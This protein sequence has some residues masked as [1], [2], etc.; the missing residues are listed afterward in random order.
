MCEMEF[1]AQ[2]AAAAAR[3][4]RSVSPECRANALKLMGDKLLSCKSEL[5]AANAADIAGLS[6]RASVE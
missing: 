4:L 6:W 2:Q 3:K 1:L 5:L